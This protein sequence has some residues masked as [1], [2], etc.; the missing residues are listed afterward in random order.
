MEGLCSS[1]SF[2]AMSLGPVC[3]VVVLLTWSACCG[4]LGESFVKSTERR[5][6]TVLTWRMERIGVKSYEI[7]LISGR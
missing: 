2:V 4:K 6:K 5:E 7:K 1:L 3:W